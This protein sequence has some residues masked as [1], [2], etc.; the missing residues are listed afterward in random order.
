MKMVLG[1]PDRMKAAGFG[2][3]GFDQH[4]LVELFLAAVELRKKAGEMEKGESHPC[5]LILDMR[6]RAALRAPAQV[7]HRR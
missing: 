2:P 3:V 7:L 5:I 1:K 6:R 4:I